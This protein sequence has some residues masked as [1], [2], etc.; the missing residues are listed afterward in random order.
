VLAV[1][2][3]A[4][5]YLEQRGVEAPRLSAELL[6]ADVLR[7]TRLQLYLDFDRPLG[8]AELQAMREGVRRRGTHEPLAYVLG[9]V[10][11]CELEIA[12]DKRVLIP[13]PETEELVALAAERFPAGAR[14]IDWGTG[15]GAVAVALSVRRPDLYIV[16]LDVSQP[17]LEVAARNVGAHGVGTRV[18]LR[19]GSGYDALAAG[20]RYGGLVANPPYIDPA[21]NVPADDDVRRFEPHVALFTPP[22]DPAASYREIAAS[23]AR[24]LSPGAWCLL[25]TGPGAAEPALRALRAS[26]DLADVDLR[27]DLAGLPRYLIARVA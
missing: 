4:A 8:A 11:F 19:C 24:W 2:K 10:S 21:G 15:S 13:R 20:T 26:P 14:C 16:G 12:V 17:A 5:G 1:V 6:L 25:E 9:H 27:A 18:E 22:G 3:A 7:C 23:A